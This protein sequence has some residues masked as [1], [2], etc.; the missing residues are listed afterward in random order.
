MQANRGLTL[1]RQIFVPS[2]GPLE[3]GTCQPVLSFS[4]DVICCEAG[5]HRC[6]VNVGNYYDEAKG[7]RRNRSAAMY[8]TS[9]FTGAAGASYNIGVLWRKEK[10][11]KGAL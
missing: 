6:K 2:S 7:V 4:P 1:T 11:F 10:Q 3:R 9:E 8:C 5:R